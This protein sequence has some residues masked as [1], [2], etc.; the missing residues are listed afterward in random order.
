MI[1]G[2]RSLAHGGDMYT[3]GIDLGGTNIAVGL[4]DGELNMIDKETAHTGAARP[5]LEIVAD[6]AA[7]SRRLIERNG[8]T[9]D[10]IDYIGI[11]VPGTVDPDAGV[12][13]CTPNLPFSGLKLREEFKKLLP[14]KKI[15]LANDANG[16]A[17]AEARVGAG[18]GAKSLVMITLGTGIGGGVII[19]GKIFTGGINASGAE[20]GHT[21]IVAG[22]ERCGCGRLGCWEAYASATALKRMTKKR[23]EEL[24]AC[25]SDS[26]LAKAPKVNA[27]VAFD[28]AKA[29]DA[30]GKRLVSEYIN[31]LAI[32]VTNMI[33]IFQ[34][35]VLLIGG[36]IS[37]EGENLTR[38]LA[39]I[40]NRE[41]YTRD[42][43]VKTRIMTAKL[44]NDAGIIGAA[45]LGR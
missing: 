43:E 23:I 33:N 30:E 35:E 26:M 41:Q 3:I 15:Y 9:V 37:G 10:D 25:G 14:I 24:L 13:E 12:V 31:Y 40:V 17:L 34:P 28:A 44:G 1:C 16:A 21:V 39:E 22:G 5:A 6:M 36:G 2:E 27:R 18:R 11:L 19:D 38:P 42:R 20:L 4:C 7:T 8:L 32:G 45:A 29:G